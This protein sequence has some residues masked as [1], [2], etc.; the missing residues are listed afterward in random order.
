ML[1]LRRVGVTL[2]LVG[3]LAAVFV[4]LGAPGSTSAWAFGSL[5]PAV[6]ALYGVTCVGNTGRCV[7]VGTGFHNTAVILVSNDSGL[8]WSRA[9]EPSGVTA[10]YGVSC[11]TTSRC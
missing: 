10:T 3:V 11:T 8:F 9:L 7:A 6:R 5:P 4:L 1:R 2:R